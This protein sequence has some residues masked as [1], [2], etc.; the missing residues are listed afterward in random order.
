MVLNTKRKGKENLYRVV[1][2]GRP[3]KVA[4]ESRAGEASCVPGGCL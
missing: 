2:K 4:W 3:E 1:E